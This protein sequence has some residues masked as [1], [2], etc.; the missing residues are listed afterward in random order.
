[1]GSVDDNGQEILPPEHCPFCGAKV[2]EKG[3]HLFCSN[4]VDCKPQLLAALAHFASKG[5]MDIQGL[6]E[7]T[8]EAFMDQLGVRCPADLYRLTESQ[9][10]A[11]KSSP[12]PL[13][14]LLINPLVGFKRLLNTS[15]TIR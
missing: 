11:R 2:V 3:A 7:K 4:T 15:P 5:C 13:K 14:K 8:L 9:L 10:L 6:N 12:H 1:M